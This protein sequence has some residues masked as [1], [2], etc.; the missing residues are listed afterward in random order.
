MS[1]KKDKIRLKNRAKGTQKKIITGVCLVVLA[2]VVVL[3]VIFAGRF[4]PGGPDDPPEVAINDPPTV[5]DPSDPANPDNT[6]DPATPDVKPDI[7]AVKDVGKRVVATI[8]GNMITQAE[9]IFH[10]YTQALLFERAGAVGS[11]EIW[12]MDFGDG[13]TAEDFAKQK[14]LESIRLLKECTKRAKLKGIELALSRTAEVEQLAEQYEGTIPKAMVDQWGVDASI[15]ELC[16]LD[17]AYYQALFES[18]TRDY[19]PELPDYDEDELAKKIQEEIDYWTT[20]AREEGTLGEDETFTEKELQQ[21]KDRVT[22]EFMLPIVYPLKLAYFETLS[23]QWIEDIDIA[24]NHD[25]YDPITIADLG[26]QGNE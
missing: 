11:V 10:L 5:N 16:Q 14:T 7:T 18:I 21:I 9:F 20:N 1:A 19:E 4:F 25:I 12:E 22:E 2:A 23:N 8:D 24:I 3:G 13:L 17:A 26:M 6:N 15:I